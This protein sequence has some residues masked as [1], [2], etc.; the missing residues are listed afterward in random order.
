MRFFF[1]GTLISGSCNP[2]AETV[3]LNLT[4]LGPATIRGTLYAIP[5]AQGWYP[6]LLPGTGEVAGRL[7]EA[8]PGFGSAELA[9]L[10]AWEDF[11]AASPDGS[12][13]I[14]KATSIAAGDG[15]NCHAQ[16]YHYGQ[17]LPDG[18]VP[19]PSG[20]FAKF[21]SAGGH[22]AFGG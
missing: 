10:D 11:D 3:H 17:P 5:D 16:V 18:A 14:R 4:D 19:I 21:L 9:A 22:R 8:T 7:Y 12:L 6:A 20:D 13:Y 2:V 15:S 1:Y